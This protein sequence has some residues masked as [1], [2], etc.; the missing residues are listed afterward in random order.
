MTVLANA[1]P[2]IALAKLNRLGLLSDLYRVVQVPRSVYHEVVEQGLARGATDAGTIRLFL[3]RSGWPIL[4]VP[5][6]TIRG[7]DPLV[8]LD[9]GERDLLILAQSIPEALLL[10]DD[11][12]AR[13]EARR[14]GLAVRGTLGILAQARRAGLLTLQEVELLLLEIAT[15]RDIWISEKLC[16]DVLAKLPEEST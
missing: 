4:E 9:P 6:P 11:E 1:G 7:Y 8:V 3:D 15:R 13:G 2:L 10:I 14:L 12:I 16:Q 5:E